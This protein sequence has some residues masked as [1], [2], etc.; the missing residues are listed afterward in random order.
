MD[1]LIMRLSA[2]SLNAGAGDES[3][4]QTPAPLGPGVSKFQGQLGRTIWI[5]PD[6]LIYTASIGT[7]YGG[8][9][10]YV[11]LRAAD[12]AI[13]AIGQ[14]AFADITVANWTKAYQVTQ[15]EDLSASGIAG[16]FV[17]GIFINKL[18]YGNYWLIQIG[19]VVPVQFRATLSETGIVGSAVYAASADPGIGVADNALAD[20]LTPNTAPSLF[21]D[22]ALMQQ[23][24]LG[25]AVAAPTSGGLTAVALAIQD[26]FAG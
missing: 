21:S 7:L 15:D 19:G 1:S 14:I 3:I 20:V 17:A 24:Y 9:F 23:R 4:G 13:A 8:W 10:R 22:T 2:G 5:P 18:K 6:Q 16:K 25:T 26:P 11:K 12:A